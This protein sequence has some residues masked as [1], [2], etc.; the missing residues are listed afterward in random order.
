MGMEMLGRGLTLK[1]FLRRELWEWGGSLPNSRPCDQH[2][3][4]HIQKK[5][6]SYRFNSQE[7]WSVPRAAKSRNEVL[8]KLKW[9]G[10]L[11]AYNNNIPVV[12]FKSHTYHNL[13]CHVLEKSLQQQSTNRILLNPFFGRKCIMPIDNIIMYRK[14]NS[15]VCG[16]WENR[17]GSGRGYREQKETQLVATKSSPQGAAEN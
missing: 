17:E 14:C 15:Q 4:W 12:H 3:H 10:W 16:S 6:V 13:Q 7:S 1:G 5:S 9:P 8:K 11:S 2:G